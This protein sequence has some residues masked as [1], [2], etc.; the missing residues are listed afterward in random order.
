MIKY[1]LE[2]VPDL[3]S[4]LNTQRNNTY[5]DFVKY[6][7]Q[8]K[9]RV[10]QEAQTKQVQQSQQTAQYTVEKGDSP[11]RIAKK[12]GISLDELYN[13]NPGIK[14][15]IIYPGDK[16]NVEPEYETKIVNLKDEQ[17]FEERLD[18]D[19]FKTIQSAPHDSNY[20][21]LDKKKCYYSSI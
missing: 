13:Y 18:G 12:A 5:L 15:K 1:S 17:S 6:Q 11:W 7:Q 4:L 21:I 8:K 20:A 10:Q 3:I 14:G 2:N 9:K 19:N 16:L